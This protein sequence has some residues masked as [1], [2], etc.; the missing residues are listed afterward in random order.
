LLV[1]AAAA[2]LV[3]RRSLA[4]EG[5]TEAHGLSIFGD[6]KYP[7]GFRHFDYVN[8][9][10]PKG[11]VFSAQISSVAGNQN[12]ETFNTLNIFVLRG[13]G[14]AGMG[15]TFDSLMA[16]ALDEPDAMYGVVARAVRWSGDGLTYRFLLRPEARFHDGS[17]LAA[18]DVA[19]SLMTLKEKGHPR[20]S[21]TIRLMT[22]AAA[23]GD[24]VVVV[25]FAPERSR[26]LPLTVASLP[27][28]SEDYYRGR[29]FEAATLEAP[30]GSGPYKVGR[31]EVGRYIEFERDAGY[32]AK[33]LPTSVGH[34]NF[35]RIRYEYY[36]DRDVAFEAFKA[37]AFTYREEF[38][39]RIWNTGYDFQAVKDGRV[40][41]EVLPDET[42][43]GMQGWWLNARRDKFRDPRLREAVGLA[44]DFEWTNQNLMYGAYRRTASFFENS[45]MKAEGKPSPEELALLE[46]WRGK[47]PDEVFGEPYAPPKSDG[48]GQDRNLLRRADQL[49]RE[50]GCKRDGNVLRLPS[51]QPFEIE[52]LDSSPALQPHTQP[53]IK[54]LSLIGIQARSR[55]VDA[56]QYQRRENEFDFDVVVRR[57]VS[58]L[59]PGEPLRQ[60]FGSRAADIKGSQNLA[61][62][63]HPAVD[64]LLERIVTARTRDELRTACRALDRVLRA[65]RYWVPMWYS[66]THRV[67]HWDV[68]GRPER[69][70][71][72]D[73]G[74]PA[75]WWHDADKAK[76]IG[77][78]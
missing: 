31:F 13:D 49:L 53:Y 70:P 51:G 54:N 17:K 43:S 62:V 25:T 46:P 22:S 47:V 35:E 73:L 76:R 9:Q 71:K 59:T 3:P 5:E 58:G 40:K 14:A 37:G 23:E 65:G 41:Q 16:R 72:Y 45:D 27:I 15:L 77:R 55:V 32:W 44:F 48:S 30:L 19:F 50:A 42:P 57:Y 4:L 34:H 38:T 60:I 24:D 29:D 69:L 36:R 66:A 20:I 52:F 12:F 61:G 2:A 68:F 67:A 78:A 33:D 75:I 26:D 11:G 74:V 1:T 56:A 39:S 18:R 10:A 28:L 21:Q 6:L 64:A 63:A 8:P 7:A